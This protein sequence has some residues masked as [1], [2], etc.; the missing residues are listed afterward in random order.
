KKLSA[1]M[2][3]SLTPAGGKEVLGVAS[4]EA[5]T[6]VDRD[7]RTAYINDLDVESV[8]FPSLDPQAAKPLE[9]LFKKMVPE[10]G[11]PISVDRLLADL[12]K[13]KVEVR[14]AA[15]DNNPPKIFFSAGP[16]VLL[17]VYG[18][19][20]LSPIEGTDLQFVVNTNWNLFFDNAE[21]KYYLLIERQWL[22][23]NDVS[24]P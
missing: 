24:G 13:G 23:A 22:T 14:T 11:E 10:N 3:F 7:T 19:P 17:M 5:D 8:R 1:R 2:A 20:V 6:K 16:G 21:K 18:K 9:D 15:L 12:D 4:L